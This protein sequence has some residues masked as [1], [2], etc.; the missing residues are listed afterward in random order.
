MPQFYRPIVL[1]AEP[2][3]G[4]PETI[5]AWIRPD[6]YG[7]DDKLM[8]HAQSAQ[9]VSAVEIVLASRNTNQ[10]K[11][12]LVWAGDYA[13][14]EPGSQDNL[15]TLCTPNEEIVPEESDTS[16]Y[17]FIVNHTKGQFVS[18]ERC[19]K[20]TNLHPLPILTREGL[21]CTEGDYPRLHR[22]VGYWARDEISVVKQKPT[23][24]VEIIFDLA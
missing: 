6:N 16:Y 13:V 11:H 1:G 12:R 3:K 15:Y 9:F 2:A 17:G 8:T 14:N 5:H 23:D 18:K 7:C 10:T 4:Q 20:Y 19:E 21:G 24:L 22:L